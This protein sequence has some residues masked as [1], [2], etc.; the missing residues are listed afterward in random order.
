MKKYLFILLIFISCIESKDEN[1]NLL[2]EIPDNP[3]SVITINNFDDI[4]YNEKAFLKDFFETNFFDEKLFKSINKFIYSKH[5]IGKQDFGNI[6]FLEKKELNND[7][8]FKDSIIYNDQKIFLFDNNNTNYYFTKYSR[9]DIVSD[10]K[11]LIENFTR[12]SDYGSNPNSKNLYHLAK[13]KSNNISVFLH[14]DFKSKKLQEL[15]I[16]LSNISN[17]TNLEF[18]IKNDEIIIIGLSK[19]DSKKRNFEIIKN[20]KPQ[21]S[22]ILNILPYDFTLFKSYAFNK[23]Y[24]EKNLKDIINKK[25]NKEIYLNPIISESDEF[26]YF[27]NKKDSVLIIKNNEFKIDTTSSDFNLKKIYRNEKIYL[28]ENFKTILS[29]FD[30]FNFLNETV[31]LTKL[32]NNI[33][34]SRN[35]QSIE[36]LILSHYN[37][38]KFILNKDLENYLKNIPTKN[39]SLELVKLENGDNEFTIWIKSNQIKDSIIYSSLYNSKTIIKNNENKTELILSK[40]FQNEIITQPQIID[41]HK[42]GQKNIIFQDSD[43]KLVLIDF[44]GKTIWKRKLNRSIN[45][46]IYQVDTYKNNRLQFLFSTNKELILLDINGEIVKQ[47]DGKSKD[48]F[49]NLSV[50]DYDKN[51]NYRYVFQNS[52][53]LKMYNSSFEIVKGF[54]KIKLSDGLMQPIKHLRILNRDYLVLKN[55]DEKISI[56]DRRGN[57]R[58]KIPE[59]ISFTSNLYKYKNGMI[60]HDSNNNIIRID[61]SGKISKQK[62]V[63][64]EKILFANNDNKITFG[65]NK[66]LVNGIE[67]TLPYGSYQDLKIQK[68][69]N[70]LYYSIF[71][72]DYKK[73]YLFKNDKIIKGFP[74]FSSSDIDFNYLNNNIFTVFLGDKNEIQLYSIN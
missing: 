29:E 59:N 66:L 63:D 45:S 3:I 26:G 42:T 16:K 58:I 60:G 8:K 56:L 10:N 65:T 73:I 53:N 4:N 69:S 17:W 27:F 43:N 28:I 49:K 57:I 20:I 7:I 37:K 24:S 36:K 2:F 31:H 15:N 23:N 68:S 21:K 54:K 6:F 71:D 70:N 33:I 40:S 1:S 22:E 72:K 44:D 47:I 5:K 64:N 46:K 48:Y 51:K 11:F 74:F 9:F 41:N 19:L 12:G 34:I 39:S 13:T 67:K 61:I 55:D 52:N 38:S 50:F 30:E 32:N 35:I 14:E 25:N 18:N 62:L